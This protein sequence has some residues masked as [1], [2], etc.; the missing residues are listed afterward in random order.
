[1]RRVRHA[2]ILLAAALAVAHAPDPVRAHT[3]STGLAT[4]TVDGRTLTYRLL[5]VPIELPEDSR[6]LFLAAAEGDR[7]SAEKVVAILRERVTIRSG[8]QPCRPGRALVQGSGAGDARLSL[9]LS[10]ECPAY[11]ALRI[12]DDWADVFGGHHQTLARIEGVGGIHE[13]AFLP[14]A[15]EAV[16]PAGGAGPAGRLGFFRLGMEHIL[17]GYDHLFFLAALLLGGGGWLALLKIVTA[18]TLAHSL[19]L[20][21][22]TLG[23]V[24][25][26]ARLIEPLIAA[27][28]VWVAIENLVPRERASRR[29]MVG[30]GFGLIHGLGF[31]E[32]LQPLALPPGAL[33]RALFGF[34]LGV[35]T[36][37]ALV[38][39]LTVPLVLWA[40]GVPWHGRAARGASLAVALVGTVWLVERLFLT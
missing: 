9:E 17:T 7:A 39:A 8:E 22:A 15:R 27:S 40:R 35:E 16:I 23:L 6:G 10:L 26:S 20:G 33:A 12:R 24:S 29:W 37:Q 11:G 30:F 14:D 4:L 1:M 5:L 31:A 3:T 32:V 34:N 18:F 21:L 38:I 19:T 28:I 13:I 36:G 2:T 25:V